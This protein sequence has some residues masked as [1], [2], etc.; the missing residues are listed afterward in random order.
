MNRASLL[1]FFAAISNLGAVELPQFPEAKWSVR[2]FGAKADG[3]TNDTVAINAAIEKCSGSGGGSVIFPEGRYAAASI[4]LRSNVRLLLDDHAVITGAATGYDPPEANAFD[5]YQ[6]FGHS[7]FHNALM[8]GE[9]IEN[10]ALVGGRVNGGALVEDE[11]DNPRSGDKLIA[12]KSGRRL[13]FQNVAHEKGAHFV[14]LLNDCEQVTLENVTIAQSRDGV[15]LVSCREVDVHGCRITGCGDD[16]IALKSDYALGRKIACANIAV[17]DCRLESAGSA[18]QIG[19]ES[20]GDFRN[21]AFKR[22]DVGRTEKSAIGIT[23]TDG[24]IVDGVSYSGITIR[25]AACPVYLRVNDRL[26]SGEAERT[27]GAIRNI[28]LSDLDVSEC[29]PARDV[30]VSPS[31]ISGKAQ[32][33]IENVSFENVKIVSAGGGAKPANNAAPDPKGHAHKAFALAPAAALFVTYATNV[34]LQNI[35]F[36][37]DKPDARPSIAGSDVD[38][39]TVEKFRAEKT[40]HAFFQFENVSQFRIH[41]SP[42]L[43]DR[44]EERARSLAISD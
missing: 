2:D 28:S 19:S 43:R 13:L 5:A 44:T 27:I 3:K 31:I 36:A 35:S 11:R 24:G 26:R 9:N 42:P 16:A 37:Y 21:I 23:C 32:S 41:N 15:N 34:Q 38:G 22:I 20:V 29:Q 25:K 4:H 30:P 1:A 40:G 6:D 33:R 12:I 7:H 8:W 10:F 18:M 14:Y 39:L 17:S